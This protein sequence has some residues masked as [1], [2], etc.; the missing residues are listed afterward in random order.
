MVDFEELKENA[1]AILSEKI[2]P[3]FKA[4]AVNIVGIVLALIALS[5]IVYLFILP[6]PLLQVSV[7][8]VDSG[9]KPAAEDAVEVAVFGEGRRLSNFVDEYGLAIFKSAPRGSVS[10]S[11]IS[12]TGTLVSL[13]GSVEKDLGVMGDY[14]ASIQMARSLNAHFENSEAAVS[15]PI[16]CTVKVPTKLVISD[17]N[18]QQLFPTD[19]EF[20]VDSSIAKFVGVIE[21]SGDEEVS[22]ELVSIGYLIPITVQAEDS[23]AKVG[24]EASGKVRIK[25]TKVSQLFKIKVADK[26][27]FR[28]KVSKSSFTSPD[29]IFLTIE[30]DAKGPIINKLSVA[31][32]GDPNFAS[33]IHVIEPEKVPS[34]LA[35]GETVN[36]PISIQT[37]GTE[38]KYIAKIVV[39]DGNCG[40]QEITLTYENKA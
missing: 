2:V 31:F 37:P 17:V 23:T 35:A 29:K 6:K 11:A 40:K 12:T 27:K 13:E 14:S 36:I 25:T 38:L 18:Y 24:S 19:F 22:D 26:P 34:K 30:N 3:W 4:N 10:V 5:A 1:S 21:K 16:G 28:V 15:I 33:Q 39:S 32:E 8:I 9:G 7:S 20:A